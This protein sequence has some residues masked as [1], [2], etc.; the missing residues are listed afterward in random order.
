MQRP[1]TPSPAASP[2]PGLRLVIGHA[3][4]AL[5]WLLG[6]HRLLALLVE[7]AVLQEVL[8]ALQAAL[9]VL[10]SSLWWAWQWRRRAAAGSALSAGRWPGPLP[11]ASRNASP[12]PKSRC[13]ASPSL[14]RTVIDWKSVFPPR[15]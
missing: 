14:T 3:V 12:P 13:S 11:P 6:A 4:V 5:V 15:S 10:G 9:F 7:D 1:Q 8:I 2:G